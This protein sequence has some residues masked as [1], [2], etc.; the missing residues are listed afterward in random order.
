MIIPFLCSSG[1]RSHCSSN[2]V[3]LIAAMMKFS[4]GAVG[5]MKRTELNEYE[6]GLRIV[7]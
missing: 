7:F 1:G 2:A 5:A 4:G 3:E 6:T